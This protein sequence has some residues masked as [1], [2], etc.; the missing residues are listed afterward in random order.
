VTGGTTIVVLRGEFDVT[1][2]GFLSG[3]L[4]RLRADQPRRLVFETAQVAF[5]DCAAARLVAGTGGWLP[6]GGKP[7]ISHPSPAVDRV[8]RASGIGAGC[9]IR[10]G[11][12]LPA[13]G[14][15]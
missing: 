4:E 9:E 5:M 6:P 11:G 7:V 3:C 2:A 14:P 12:V 8:L 15:P 13:A 10:P 1:T